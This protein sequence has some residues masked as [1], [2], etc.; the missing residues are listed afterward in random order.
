VQLQV[1]TCVFFSEVML[2]C[3]G[4]HVPLHS[5]TFISYKSDSAAQKCDE[6]GLVNWKLSPRFMH[7]Q[8]DSLEVHFDLTPI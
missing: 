5:G 2:L 4:Y 7:G 6:V 1:E 8:R 3:C